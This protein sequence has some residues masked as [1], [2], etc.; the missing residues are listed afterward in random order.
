MRSSPIGDSGHVPGHY[1]FASDDLFRP[2][3]RPLCALCRYLLFICTSKRRSISFCMKQFLSCMS[4]CREHR[5]QH[6]LP[7]SMLETMLFRI[8]DHP[9]SC[10]YKK[11]KK[12]TNLTKKKRK[13]KKNEQEKMTESRSVQNPCVH[14]VC[15]GIFPL[16][17]RML[18]VSAATKKEKKSKPGRQRDEQDKTF[19]AAPDTHF[20]NPI[21]EDKLG[22][23]G[24]R[25]WTYYYMQ[26]MAGHGLG[27]LDHDHG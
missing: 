16:T 2:L 6:V 13:K 23:G 26:L 17:G 12:Y 20:S 1:H 22:L 7:S 24:C 25:H 18:I 14:R 5:L 9:R 21:Q 15:L 19:S 8:R 11:Q 3:S 4:T 27:T 10:M